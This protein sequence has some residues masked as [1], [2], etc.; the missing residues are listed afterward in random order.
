[1]DTPTTFRYRVYGSDN[2]VH[3]TLCVDITFL[4]KSGT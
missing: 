4:D 3:D 1:M 2:E